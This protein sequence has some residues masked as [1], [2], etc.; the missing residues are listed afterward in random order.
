MPREGRKPLGRVAWL[1]DPS[2]NYDAY[3]VREQIYEEA[4]RM[5]P[6]NWRHLEAIAETVYNEHPEMRERDKKRRREGIL[7]PAGSAAGTPSRAPV[8]PG[9]PP[10]PVYI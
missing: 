9:L 1:K 3:L 6:K 8:T 7:T 4:K 2:A 5:Q 10:L